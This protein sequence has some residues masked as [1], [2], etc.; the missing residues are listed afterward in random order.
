MWQAVALK[1]EAELAPNISRIRDHDPLLPMQL[2]LEQ[3]LPTLI[4]LIPSGIEA[5]IRL[6]KDARISVENNQNL[7]RRKTQWLTK[8]T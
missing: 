3:L 4:W 1:K 5:L 8:N 2:A 7:P 6:E